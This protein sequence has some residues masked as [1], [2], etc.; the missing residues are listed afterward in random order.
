MNIDAFPFRRFKHACFFHALVENAIGQLDEIRFRSRNGSPR[1]FCFINRIADVPHESLRLDRSH[2]FC[3]FGVAGGLR[4][5]AD[6]GVKV[7][8]AKPFQRLANGEEWS[9]AAQS[10]PCLG[11]GIMVSLGKFLLRGKMNDGR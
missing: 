2:G 4:G 10:P 9:V 11:M 5:M 7:R 8:G 3:N 6:V 1:F